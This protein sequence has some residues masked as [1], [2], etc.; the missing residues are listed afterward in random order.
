[1]M[2]E[3]IIVT[4]LRGSQEQNGGSKAITQEIVDAFYSFAL[5]KNVFT[6]AEIDAY[7]TQPLEAQA[8]MLEWVW[9]REAILSVCR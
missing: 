4:E 1:M 6:R 3:K 8:E 9:T 7:K 5:R 2:K